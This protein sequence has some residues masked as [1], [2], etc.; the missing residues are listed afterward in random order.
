MQ[1]NVGLEDNE[2]TNDHIRHRAAD[3][4]LSDLMTEAEAAQLTTVPAIVC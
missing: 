2:P 1:L 3:T 4:D